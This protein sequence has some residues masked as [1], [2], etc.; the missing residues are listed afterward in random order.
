MTTGSSLRLIAPLPGPTR[1]IDLGTH[2][3]AYADIGEGPPAIFLHGGLMDHTSWGNQAPLASQC[4]MILISTR[5]HGASTGGDLEATYAAFADDALAVMDHLELETAHLIGFS[6]GG[7]AALDL[8]LRAPDRLRSLTLIGTPHE[9]ASYEDGVLERMARMQPADMDAARPI[10]RELV[11]HLRNVM[12]PED[13]EAYWPRI[14]H[15]LWLREPNFALEALAKIRVPTLILHGEHEASIRLS[16][17]EALARAIPGARLTVVPG[18][19]HAS[20]QDAPEAVNA[21]LSAF[22]TAADTPR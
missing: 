14:I 17:S 6:D 21:A 20:A 9:L 15:G 4:R 11:T 7:C 8:A 2:S 5:G 16:A 1:R 13:W 3:L 19:S 10:V 12:S 22:L 18:G